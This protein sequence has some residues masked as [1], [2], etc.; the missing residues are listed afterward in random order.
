MGSGVRHV[1]SIVLIVLPIVARARQ[2]SDARSEFTAR[3]FSSS[4]CD[5]SAY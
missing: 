5:G 4:V 2:V 1:C 3:T